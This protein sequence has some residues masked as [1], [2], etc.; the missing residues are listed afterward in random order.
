MEPHQL[1]VDMYSMGPS[2]GMCSVHISEPLFD[3]LN[4]KS[5]QEDYRLVNRGES[6][7]QYSRLA[8]CINMQPHLNE[9]IVVVGENF[10]DDG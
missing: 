8:C 4:K 10:S 3:S 1:P 5:L 6:N 7:S 2:C 9:M